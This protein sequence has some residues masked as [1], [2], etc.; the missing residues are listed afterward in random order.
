MIHSS[1]HPVTPPCTQAHLEAVRQAKR[2]LHMSPVLP[3]RAERGEV[4]ERDERLEGVLENKMIFT[5]I[6]PNKDNIVRMCGIEP[7]RTTV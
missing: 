7:A 1:K 2:L 6:S 5:D 3:E 4:I